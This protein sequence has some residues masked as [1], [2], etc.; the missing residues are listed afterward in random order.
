LPTD[1]VSVGRS[2][3]CA[4]QGIYKSGRVLTFQGHAEFDEWINRETVTAFGKPIWSQE[5]LEAALEKVKGEDDSLY[6]ARVM[7]EFF[8]EE[9]VQHV[10]SADKGEILVDQEVVVLEEKAI[11]T[12]IEVR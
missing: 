9:A 4:L 5:V 10:E 3:H 2:D 7:L 11:I 6:A 1:F 12:E 8:A